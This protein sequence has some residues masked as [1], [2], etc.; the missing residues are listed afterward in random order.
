MGRRVAAEIAA[1]VLAVALAVG[2]GAVIEQLTGLRLYGGLGGLAGGLVGAALLSGRRARR[3]REEGIFEI[4]LRSGGRWSSGTAAVAAG[5][6]SYRRGGP[7]GLRFPLHPAVEYA[8]VRLGER[9]DA[10]GWR[11]AWSLM[12]GM[13]VYPLEGA[14][15]VA[16]AVPRYLAEPL[17]ARLNADSD[18]APE[19]R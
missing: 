7:A 5:S 2:L 6:L 13:P 4:A 12:P 11:T 1:V 15:N 9:V 8:A 16:I 19:R 14:A 3:A 17:R 18:D 10:T